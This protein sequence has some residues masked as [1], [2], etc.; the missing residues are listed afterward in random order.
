[1]N[2]SNG[3]W[4]LPEG[5]E[6]TT[7]EEVANVVMG[8]S[9]PSSTYNSE[10]IGLPFYQGKAEF[11]EMYP[12]PVKWC[13]RPQKIAEAGDV[14]MSVRAPVGST[15]LA[16]ET[17]CIGR[18]LVAIRAPSSMSPLYILYYLRVSEQDLIDKATGTTFQAVSG[19]TVR[20]HPIPLAPLPEQERIAAEI[21]K[22]FSRLDTA[23]AALK[24]AQAG[25]ARYRASVLKAAV[26]GRLVPQDPDDEPATDL[27]ARI[28][29][30]RRAKW[31]S[32]HPGKRYKEPQG[33][34]TAE[35]GELPA[36]W[37]WASMETL[38]DIVSGVAKGRKFGDRATVNLPYLR[39]AN[40]Q[41]GFLDL[42]EIKTIEALPDELDK[43]KLQA[44]DLVLTEGGD[45]DKLGRS[46][47]WRDQVANCIHQNHI[48]RARPFGQLVPT[49][50]LMFATNSEYGRK[51][52][53]D[54]SKQTTNLA[55]INLTQLRAFPV[56]LPPKSEMRSI[57]DQVEAFLSDADSSERSVVKSDVRAD[58][59]R[60][61]ILQKAFRGELV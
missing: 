36:G 4:P 29:A 26:E 52:F 42:T 49:E 59:L 11:G 17:S 41:Q 23:V 6:W 35:L 8:Q 2:G 15:N 38:A 22:Q 1:M 32:D 53:G 34:D 13:S 40:V 24:R 31:E 50:W 3:K 45:W 43:Y 47:I 44:D 51:Y 19:K 20:S 61:A 28:L 27:L 21:E 39:V 37:V 25:L 10:G 55:S 57:I 30:E 7:I 48:F 5:W 14:L 12:T 54:S 56:P 58:R 9:P 60:Q 16:R 46:A 18:G 33:P